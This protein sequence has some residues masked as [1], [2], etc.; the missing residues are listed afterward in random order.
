VQWCADIEVCHLDLS[1]LV[2][3]HSTRRLAVL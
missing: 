1:R 3:G 2:A